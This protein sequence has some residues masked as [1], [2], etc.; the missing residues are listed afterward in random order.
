MIIAV[1]FDGTLHTGEYPAIGASAPY[2]AEIIQRLSAEGHYI[3][4]WTCREG[5]YQTDMINWLIEHE[6]PFNR[7]NNHAPGR[8]EEYGYNA[9]KVFADIYIDDRQVGGLPTWNEIYDIISGRVK[10]VWFYE[11]P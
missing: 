11:K 5:V 2:A 3:I 9:R 8:V 10:P 6:I 7:V 4:I 1:D